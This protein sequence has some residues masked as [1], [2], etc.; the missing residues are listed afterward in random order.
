MVH[1]AEL[2]AV[3]LEDHVPALQL[4]HD[5]DEL[6]PEDKLAVARARDQ[7]FG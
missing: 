2:V 6:A 5:E 3:H 4:I 1:V 7:A